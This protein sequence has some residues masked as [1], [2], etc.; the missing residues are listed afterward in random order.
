[1]LVLSRKAGEAIAIE[2]EI[3]VKVLSVQ[4]KTVKIG[5]EAPDSVSISRMELVLD[6]EVAAVADREPDQV[7]HRARRIR[8][9]RLLDVRRNGG[10]SG[11]RTAM[12]PR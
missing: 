6:T 4:G 3:R 10:A 9:E 2:G 8:R 1:M 7:N 11:M 12:I 5:I